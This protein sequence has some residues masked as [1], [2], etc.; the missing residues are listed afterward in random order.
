MHWK[1]IS[2]NP[3]RLRCARPNVRDVFDL[4]GISKDRPRMALIS[5]ITMAECLTTLPGSNSRPRSSAR[6]SSDGCENNSF[7][8]FASTRLLQARNI[9][10][11]RGL[12]ERDSPPAREAHRAPT[13][14]CSPLRGHCFSEC[15]TFR[16]LLSASRWSSNGSKVT[17]PSRRQALVICLIEAIVSG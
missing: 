7:R 13:R 12:S 5:S 9:T 17:L 11:R 4:C 1:S 2:G 16:S 8:H 6:L 10:R 15:V 14:W 3:S